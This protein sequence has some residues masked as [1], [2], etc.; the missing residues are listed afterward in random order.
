MIQHITVIGTPSDKISIARLIFNA[1]GLTSSLKK[2]AENELDTQFSG[3][4]IESGLDIT[5]GEFISV[6]HLIYEILNIS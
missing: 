5:T 4:I 2:W 3:K 6:P 1:R